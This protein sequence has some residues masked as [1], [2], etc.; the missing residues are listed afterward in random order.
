MKKYITISYYIMLVI[1][2]WLSIACVTFRVKHPLAQTNEFVTYWWEVIT[3]Q[4]VGF[5]NMRPNP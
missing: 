3:F 4:V 5:L 2:T 1:V